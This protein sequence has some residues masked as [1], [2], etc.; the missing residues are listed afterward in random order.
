MKNLKIKLLGFSSLFVFLFLT[1]CT[2][3]LDTKP[4][5]TQQTADEVYG[6]IKYY[7]PAMKVAYEKL[8]EM[9]EGRIHD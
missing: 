7:Y 2:D 9:N 5:G 1:S 6:R 3:E 8:K 4:E